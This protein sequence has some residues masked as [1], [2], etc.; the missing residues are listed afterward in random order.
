M[1][2]DLIEFERDLAVNLLTAGY[3]TLAVSGS[4][5]RIGDIVTWAFEDA[6]AQSE[7]D[8]GIMR[9]ALVNKGHPD[10][11]RTEI[12]LLQ[13]MLEHRDDE[14]NIAIAAV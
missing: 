3:V 11:C 7:L 12:S 4:A 8:V 13:A 14:T 5:G 2:D 10:W 6:A 1:R 9:A